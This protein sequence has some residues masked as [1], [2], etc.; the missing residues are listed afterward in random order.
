MTQICH[1]GRAPHLARARHD[2]LS[3]HVLVK[4]RPREGWTLTA[5]VAVLVWLSSVAASAESLYV[6]PGATGT[7]TASNPFGRIA[8]A[9]ALAGPGDQVVLRPGTYAERIRTLRGGSSASSRIVI[10]AERAG[11]ALV[12]SAAGTLLRVSHPFITVQGLVLDGRYARFDTVIVDSTASDLLLQRVEVRRSTKDCV[13][14]RAP[15][16]LVVD[17]AHIHHCLNAANGR[18]DAH[19]IVAGAVRNLTIR[20]TRIHTFSG[21]AVQ[22]DPGRAAPGWDRVTIDNCQFWLEPLTTATNG[23]AA[24]TVPGENAVDTKT[25]QS[26]P[27]AS[28]TIR[29]TRAWGFR[30]G[31]ITNMA[32]FNIKENVNAVF[33]GVT[34]SRSEIA[35][36]L[37]GPGPHGGAWARIQNTVAYDV[38]TAIR[39][40]DDIRRVEVWNVTLGRGITRLFRAA[41]SRAT[42][43]DVQ[44]V[45]YIG[46]THPVEL[47]GGSNMAATAA[48]FVDASAHDYHLASGSRSINAGVPLNAVTTDFDGVHRPAQ[49][50]WDIG[51]YEFAG[52]TSQTPN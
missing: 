37:R 41:S 48:D 3:S 16:N 27:R 52:A 35:F 36:R 9:L 2:S 29:R 39:Y 30:G 23:F 38:A 19:G 40:E 14:V 31:L 26:A 42:G 11:T 33:D 43:L 17:G 28:I 4:G 44:N 34:V 47:A 15:R 5:C 18:T 49:G 7:G 10:R 1:S 8:D 45:L 22:L 25:L 20:N 6:V 50:G 32:A 51:A 46:S 21:D 12:T 13:D 24:G